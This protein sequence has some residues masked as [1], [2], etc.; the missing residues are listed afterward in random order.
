MG[1]SFGSVWSF[2]QLILTCCK[3]SAFYN[4]EFYFMKQLSWGG[5]G[6]DM[7]CVHASVCVHIRVPVCDVHV[8]GSEHVCMCICVHVCVGRGGESN[9]SQICMIKFQVLLNAVLK[10][11]L[12]ILLL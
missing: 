8:H 1:W 6:I 5:T 9:K 10:T 7:E 4:G 3:S 11:L 12:P 2:V